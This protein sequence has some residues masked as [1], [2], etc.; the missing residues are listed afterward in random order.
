MKHKTA[1]AVSLALAASMTFGQTAQ[2]FCG[3]YVA[4]TDSPLIN[5]A[6]RVVL[7]HDGNTTQ[8]TMAS[9]VA[10]DP[11]QFGL[12]IPVPTV[13][14]KGQVKIVDSKVV[15]HLAD[16]TKPRLVQ[17]HD[18]DPCEPPRVYAMA[19]PAP[20]AAAPAGMSRRKSTV[21]IEEQYSVEEYDITVITA[22][23]AADLVAYLNKNGYKVPAGAED[24]VASY[25]RQGMHFFLAKVNMAK[26]KD[27]ASGFLRP[28]QVTYQS[29]KFM[30]PI[31]L[32]TVNADGPQDMIVLGLTKG[33]RLEV[34][35]YATRKVPTGQEIPLFVEQKFGAFYDAMFA[36]QVAENNA[37][38]FLEYAWNI[39]ACDPCSAP[40]LANGEL[41]TLG[42]TWIEAQG[43]QNAFV[44][45]LHVRYDREH[46]PEDLA[47]H[48]T[49]DKESFQAR[50]VMRHPF[51]GEPMCTA[52]YR[53]K[54]SLPDRFAKEAADLRTLTGWTPESIRAQMA[55]TGQPLR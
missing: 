25:L 12:V 13:I 31:R 38:V 21:V 54:A 52:G 3:F 27:D 48:E 14:K 28:I 9:D 8:V 5:K 15:Q 50:Y 37:S 40:P 7:A 18:G 34:A 43:M 26:M 35:N 53:Y 29:P 49:A 10:G 16:Y 45:R 23:K 55:A 24:T 17:Y 46:F 33:G 20:A 44:T 30:L 22:T 6:S 51:K 36:R 47:L 42:A 4:T 11:T 2:A 1:R 41:R 39:G 32:G 19:M